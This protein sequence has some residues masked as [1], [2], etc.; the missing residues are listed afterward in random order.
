MSQPLIYAVTLNWNR[1]QDTLACVESL[2]AQTYL[3]LTV[4]VVDN[5]SID[6]SIEQIEGQ[7][8]QVE[9]IANSANLGFAGGMNVGLRRTLAAGAAFVLIVNNDTLLAVDMVETLWGVAQASRAVVAPIIYYA[10]EPQRVWSLG[11]QS[12]P[13]TLEAKGGVRGQVDMGQWTAVIPCDFVP[14]CAMFFP[15]EALEEVGLFDEHFFMYY[16]DSD[17]CL[18]LRR[19]GWPILSVTAARM[20]HKVALS[21]GGSDSV[22]ERYWMARSSVRFFSKHARWWQWPI[23]L[24]WRMGSA[25]RTSWRLWRRKRRDAL[26]AYWRGLGDGVRELRQ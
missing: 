16:E 17:L 7:F 14:G 12:H 8:P 20:W 2:L 24:F 19:E 10:D 1:P 9:L 18:R 15:R 5:G 11:A 6:D 3:N 4:L 25:V 13:L 26:K 22:N 21:S 23:I